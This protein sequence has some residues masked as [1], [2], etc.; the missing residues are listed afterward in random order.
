MPIPIPLPVFWTNLTLVS[1]SRV[2]TRAESDRF[3]IE[4]H[5]LNRFPAFGAAQRISFQIVL[6]PNGQVDLV[7]NKNTFTGA[8]QSIGLQGPT[9]SEGLSLSFN[10]NAVSVPSSIRLMSASSWLQIED[11]PVSLPAAGDGAVQ[12]VLNGAGLLPGVYATTI[13]IEDATSGDLLYVIP[14]ELTVGDLFADSEF[15]SGDWTYV[16]EL[17]WTYTPHHP[18]VYSEVIGWCYVHSSATSAIYLWHPTAE[19]IWSHHRIFP[20]AW[21]FSA[22]AAVR[23]GDL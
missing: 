10:D 3:I 9:A 19:W 6:S 15:S 17:G 13:S 14:V 18:W 21:Q 16:E 4:F 20:W 8:V 11:A 12:V 1:D 23:I 2:W 7:Y 22:N 5:E